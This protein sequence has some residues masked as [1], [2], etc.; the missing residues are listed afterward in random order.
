MNFVLLNFVWS[1]TLIGQSFVRFW[2]II[3]VTIVIEMVLI[4]LMTSH[5]WGKSLLISLVGNLVSG[6]IGTIV[7]GSA[8]I[9]VDFLFG[10]HFFPTMFLTWILMFAGSFGL[11]YLTVRWILKIR[12]GH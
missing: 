3:P 7:T 12:A 2:Y 10:S 4:K 1:G 9:L 5:S 8:S 11:E 6:V